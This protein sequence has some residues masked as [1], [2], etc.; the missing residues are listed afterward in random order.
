MSYPL[1]A[2]LKILGRAQA[3]PA[4]EDLAL[5]KLLVPPGSQPAA[6]RLFRIRVEAFDWNCPSFI[7]PRF[8]E[9]E[10]A[11]AVLPLQARIAELEAELKRL[12]S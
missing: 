4:G 8:T 6:E 2:R 9:E 1:Q 7:T 3:V 10:V 12:K 5:A 11:E